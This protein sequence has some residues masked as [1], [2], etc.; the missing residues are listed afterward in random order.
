MVVNDTI[1]WLLST[2]LDT[3]VIYEVVRTKSVINYDFKGIWFKIRPKFSVLLWR[4]RLKFLNTFTR[5]QL[6]I[7]SLQIT[8]LLCGT[9]DEPIHYLFLN[10]T[11]TRDQLLNVTI[12][13]N[14]A[15]WEIWKHFILTPSN[16]DIRIGDVMETIGKYLEIVHNSYKN[17]YIFYQLHQNVFELF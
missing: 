17:P 6:L 9:D 15:I 14:S 16:D 11:Y 8:F 13:L 12:E 10:Y 2:Y 4:T 5:L 7:I 1:L 3:I